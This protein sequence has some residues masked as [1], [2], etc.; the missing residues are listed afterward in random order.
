MHGRGLLGPNELA[1]PDQGYEK[2]G[3]ASTS[4]ATHSF[5]YRHESRHFGRFVKLE[6]DREGNHALLE[7]GKQGRA[8]QPHRENSE[9]HSKSV[10]ARGPHGAR[11]RCPF[12]CNVITTRYL[13]MKITA[14]PSDVRPSE[15]DHQFHLRRFARR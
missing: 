13:V 12:R 10:W 11:S 3:R 4:G 14:V 7:I 6:T 15:C 5:D 9:A 8:R 1:R 2:L